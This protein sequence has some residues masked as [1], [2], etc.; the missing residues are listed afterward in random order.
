V[1]IV[2]PANNPSVSFPLPVMRKIFGIG[3]GGE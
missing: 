1:L 3:Q 2:S